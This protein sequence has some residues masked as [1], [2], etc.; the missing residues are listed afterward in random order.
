MIIMPGSKN[1]AHH[2]RRLSDLL[3]EAFGPTDLGNRNALMNR[4][5]PDHRFRLNADVED[6]VIAEALLAA[7]KSYAPYSRN[8]AGCAFETGAGEIYSGRFPTRYTCKDIHHTLWREISRSI[9]NH[10]GNW[11][12]DNDIVKTH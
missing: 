6:R 9:R 2:Q 12:Q 10:S 1:L 5:Q 8:F 4:T 3:P 11:C 7:E